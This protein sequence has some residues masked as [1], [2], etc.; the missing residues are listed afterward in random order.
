MS[1]PLIR[2]SATAL[3]VILL[4]LPAVSAAGD[5]S[6][7][8]QETL[9]SSAADVI[10][11]AALLREGRT[12]TERNWAETASRRSEYTYRWRK[13]WRRPDGKG[14]VKER[15]EL[16]ELYIP[17]GCPYGRCRVVAVKLEEN[18]KPVARER[19]EK[20]RLRAGKRLEK[21]EREA[22]KN[23]PAPAGKSPPPP[24]WLQF[25]YFSKGMFVE[26]RSVKLDGQEA[27]DQCE[28]SSPR[29]ETVGGREMIALDFA[30]R[31]GAA[32]HSQTWFMPRV[33]GR[34]WLDAADRVFVRL[35]AWPKGTRP[36]DAS[37]D[38]LLRD[39]ALAYDSVRVKEGVWMFRLGRV[40]GLKHPGLFGDVNDDFSIEVSDYLRF[41][42]EA[43][44][45]ELRVIE[46]REQ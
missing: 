30:P 13:T 11:V 12:N 28:F 40:N 41:A 2:R 31:P 10:D 19:V 9:N 8:G 34:L 36:A 1:L 24:Y 26:D 38:E 5:A 45:V 37:S 14:V 23:G 15:S 17:P 46:K 22:G 21:A 20:E 44:K 29:R 35:A 3:V 43:D 33:E 4:V 32:F 7:A 27:L 6:R 18:G 16:L 39:A 25:T 42:V